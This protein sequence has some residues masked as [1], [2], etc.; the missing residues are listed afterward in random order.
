MRQQMEQ[1]E[2]LSTNLSQNLNQLEA[3]EPGSQTYADT[4]ADIQQLALKIEALS[5]QKP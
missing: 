5:N 2:A 3:S 1:V 4:L